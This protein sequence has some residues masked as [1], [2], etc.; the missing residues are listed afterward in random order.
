VTERDP[1]EP[2]P[3]LADKIN[4]L[5]DVMHPSG[6]GPLSNEEVAAAINARGGPTISPSYLW[7]LRT[8]R[9]DNPGKHHLDALARYFGVNPAYFFDDT[10][11]EQIGAELDLLAA[12]RD[13]GV[14]RLAL[15]AAGLSR[16]AL[17]AIQLMVEQARK[18]E[19][20]PNGDRDAAAA[21]PV[22]PDDPGPRRQGA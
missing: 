22:G 12:M 10:I 20:L 5:F 18:I 7:L 16:E 4:R 13:A 11:A 9:R 17:A 2:P 3:T 1:D 14:K 6:R 8:G 19:G 21:R 15:R